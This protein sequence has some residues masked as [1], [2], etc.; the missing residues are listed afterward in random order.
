LS[1]KKLFIEPIIHF[2]E[3]AIFNHIFD[4]AISTLST[5][6]LHIHV[7]VLDCFSILQANFSFKPVSMAFIAVAESIHW[8]H[9][10]QS[11][12]LVN[13]NCSSKT[14]K[15]GK[16]LSAICSTSSVD[17]FHLASICHKANIT[18]FKSAC[19]LP[20][21]LILSHK[22]FIVASAFSHSNQ[23]HISC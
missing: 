20:T 7:K 19:H 5:K 8:F 12:F 15:I 1:C 18:Q 9:K 21:A 23:N 14:L 11:C 3:S 2:N 4:Q 22:T 10:S 16:P 13:H 6:L 17:N